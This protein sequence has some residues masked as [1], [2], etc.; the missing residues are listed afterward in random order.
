VDPRDLSTRDAVLQSSG[1]P[2]RRLDPRSRV[3]ALRITLVPRGAAVDRAT[4]GSHKVLR[5]VR[6]RTQLAHQLHEVATVVPL[7]RPQCA[8]APR[9]S[10]PLI[11][12]HQCRRLTLRKAVRDRRH[13]LGNQPMAILDQQMAEI[14]QPRFRI[15]RSAIQTRVGVSPRGM[16]VVLPLLPAKVAAA[17]VGAPVLPLKTLLTGP[18]F[19]QR[20]IDGEVLVRHQG[21]SA[22]HDTTEEAARDLL[23]QEPIAILR[24]DR[25][26][27]DR[28]VHVHPDEPPEQQVV[29]ELL[30]QQALAAKGI[31]DLEQLRPQQALG[32]NR[33]TTDPCIQPIELARHIAQHVI[34]HRAN[35]AQGVILRDTLLRRHI[36]E[37]RIRLAVV[38]SHAGHGSTRSTICRSL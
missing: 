17:P 28:L 3:L 38:T 34:D 35:R 37:H 21:R 5:H 13:R 14:G 31:K 16:D 19:D 11:V 18:G 32:R 27:P 29:I 6:C 23:I 25:R 10:L 9:R 22:L 15:I 36:T 26:R 7:V 1:P 12:H 4:A 2:E 33:R 24:E 20:A 8:A 30:H